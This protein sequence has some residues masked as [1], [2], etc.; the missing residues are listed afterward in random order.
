[1]WFNILK[2]EPHNKVYQKRVI[3][4]LEKKLSPL[5]TSYRGPIVE[6]ITEQSE[7]DY[8]ESPDENAGPHRAA[9]I[10]GMSID[11][12]NDIKHSGIFG[13]GGVIR[14]RIKG[15][16]FFDSSRDYAFPKFD[17]EHVSKNNYLY[18]GFQ[19][20]SPWIGNNPPTKLGYSLRKYD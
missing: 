17:L 18:V 14:L 9:D 4:T 1:M 20:Q 12:Y 7:S 19:A 13:T 15:K 2:L 10:T 8:E 3:E 16:Y 6:K 5:L 11:G